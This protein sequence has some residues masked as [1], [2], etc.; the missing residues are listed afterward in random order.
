MGGE[1]DSTNVGDGQVAVF[2]PISLDH[3]KRLGDTVEEIARTKSGIIKPSSSVVSAAQQPEAMAQLR[4]AAEF[5]E[6]R[7]TVQPGDFDVVSTRVAVGGQLM[8]V[9][10]LADTYSDLF[11]PLYGEHQAQNAAVAIAAV[12]AFMGGG[13][14]PLKRDLVEE[15]L[16][17]ATSPGRL[18]LIGTEPTVLVDAAHNPAGAQTLAA[19]L[20][21]YFDFNE[22]AVVVGILRDKDARGII[23][24]LT[25]VA[26]RF[27]VTQSHSERAAAYDE[28]AD[29]VAG[30]SGV[31]VEAVDDLAE[32]ME[33][34]REWAGLVPGRAV[35]VTGSITLIGEA[36]TIADEREWKA[37][38]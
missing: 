14:V 13:G 32:A 36:M 4:R 24:A 27:F 23:R 8:A 19:A 34:A 12:E 25:P 30:W 29:H 9:R 11:L 26:A 2:T 22:V 38:E 6:S 28:L 18:Q 17:G 3:T 35:V 15:G 21:T 5:S 7:L 16:A 37:G 31:P 20:P 33:A 10:G 1:W